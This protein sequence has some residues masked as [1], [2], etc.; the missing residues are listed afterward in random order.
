MVF[1]G[2]G[3]VL[4]VYIYFVGVFVAYSFVDFF[5][6]FFRQVVERVVMGLLMLVRVL[7]C[8]CWRGGR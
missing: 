3:G 4:Y 2:Q 7:L 8:M 6:L 1:R 5:P